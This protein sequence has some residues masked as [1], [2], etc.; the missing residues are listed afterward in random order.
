MSGSLTEA[1]FAEESPVEMDTTGAE[2]AESDEEFQ[3]LSDKEQEE[4]KPVPSSSNNTSDQKKRK[5]KVMYV[6]IWTCN[7]RSHWNRW[8]LSSIDLSN[9]LS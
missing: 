8:C 3:D 6:L 2:E 7:P 1:D 9:F 4:E 5:L